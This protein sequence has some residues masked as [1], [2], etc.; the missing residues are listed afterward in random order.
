MRAPKET[1]ITVRKF[2]H[3]GVQ[4]GGEGVSVE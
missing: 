2:I 3:S 4:E 1:K